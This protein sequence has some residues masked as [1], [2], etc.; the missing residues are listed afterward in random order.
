M[1]PRQ[2]EQVRFILDRY[3]RD[4]SVWAF[5]S[6]A[7][8]KRLK[9]YSDLDLAVSGSLTSRQRS[10][11]TDAFDESLLPFKVDVVEL[12][13]VDPGFRNRILPDLVPLTDAANG[14]IEMQPV[15]PESVQTAATR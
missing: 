3:L 12:D 15:A 9:Q 13:A 4:H 5:G 2:W 10:D 14:T 8:G 6:R 11:I 7:T 1:T